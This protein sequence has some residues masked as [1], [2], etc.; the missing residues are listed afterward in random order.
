MQLLI[1]LEQ[2]SVPH[3]CWCTE[4][5]C[6]RIPMLTDAYPVA[7]L[8]SG[9]SSCNIIQVHG[10]QT[11]ALLHDA[12]RFEVAKLAQGLVGRL[13]QQNTAQVLPSACWPGEFMPNQKIQ[14]KCG[15]K[16]L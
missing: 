16:A 4:L 5:S 8:L 15:I 2:V 1:W 14:E 7:E 10:I 11:L 3:V 12:R 13:I 9:N 6:L